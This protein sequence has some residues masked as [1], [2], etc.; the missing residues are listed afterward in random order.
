MIHSSNSNASPDPQSDDPI[1]DML[2]TAD[3]QEGA[4][5]Q[6]AAA[7][8]AYSAPAVPLNPNLKHRLFETLGL[9]EPETD[10][11]ALLNLSIRDLRAKAES[12]TWEVMEMALGFEIAILQEQLSRRTMACFIRAEGPGVFPN[13]Y[14]P[15]DEVLLVL[16]GDIVEGDRA[17]GA[18]DRLEATGG[19]SHH[20][21][22]TQGCLL[23]CITSMDNQFTDVS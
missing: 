6:E 22:T 20:L 23:F 16:N 18:G 5:Y 14:H 4:A 7:A 21:K 9:D 8:L 2:L 15:K 19:S 3:E 12:L 17:Y 10:I 1:L 13:H 11:M